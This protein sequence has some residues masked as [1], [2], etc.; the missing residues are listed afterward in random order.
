M[1]PQGRGSAPVGVRLGVAEALL[2]AVPAEPMQLARMPATRPALPPASI[3]PDPA[4]APSITPAELQSADPNRSNHPAE[5]DAPES[6]GVGLTVAL[7]VSLALGVGLP[8][9]LPVADGVG[10]ENGVAVPVLVTV[11]AGRAGGMGG[12]GVGAC[13][14]AYPVGLA[15]Y[16]SAENTNNNQIPRRLRSGAAIPIQLLL[17]PRIR[18][19]LWRWK[20]PWPW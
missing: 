17:H 5:R 10:V 12:G 9:E 16:G 19:R 6:V 14:G 8:L 15:Q 11:A 7:G 13:G 1:G 2:V 4:H 18:G 20:G 3:P